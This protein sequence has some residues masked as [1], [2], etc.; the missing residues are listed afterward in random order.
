MHELIKHA[1]RHLYT[2]SYTLAHT[3]TYAHTQVQSHTDNPQTDT[4]IHAQT[5]CTSSLHHHRWKKQIIGLIDWNSKSLL[6]PIITVRKDQLT[7]FQRSAN[8]GLMVILQLGHP[9]NWPR[10]DPCALQG[11]LILITEISVN[12]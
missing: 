8:R 10:P 12:H 4:Q 5:T 2:Y 7:H 6:L 11:C 9:T 1:F 3:D